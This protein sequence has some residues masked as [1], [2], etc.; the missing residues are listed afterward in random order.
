MNFYLL[1][2]NLQEDETKS[3]V[4]SIERSKGDYQVQMV[5]C[6]VIPDGK[7]HFYGVPEILVFPAGI[8]RIF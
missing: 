3:V 5:E 2:V 4:V 8:C 6:D 1:F 7:D